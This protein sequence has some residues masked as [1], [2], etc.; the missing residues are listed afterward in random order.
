MCDDM[1]DE[2]DKEIE[3]LD[4]ELQEILKKKAF[5]E[6]MRIVKIEA[7]GEVWYSCTNC[8]YFRDFKGKKL[9]LKK[10]DKDFKEKGIIGYCFHPTKTKRG[11]PLRYITWKLPRN[12][13]SDPC[14]TP[15]K[16]I[17]DDE[18]KSLWNVMF[19]KEN[20]K[21]SKLLDEYSVRKEEREKLRIKRMLREEKLKSKE[22]GRSTFFALKF[23]QKKSNKIQDKE[24]II[25]RRLLGWRI[26]IIHN[27]ETLM[28]KLKNPVDVPTRLELE[29]KLD[30]CKKSIENIRYIETI[31]E[32]ISEI[33]DILDDENLTEE[34]IKLYIQ[35]M[36]DFKKE[37][38]EDPFYST[39]V[40]LEERIGK[41]KK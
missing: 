29:K 3:K 20:D 32:K 6:Y 31:L 10:R 41:R 11:H 38:E 22:E 5:E 12:S 8:E 1:F 17:G 39:I 9:N 13:L 18:E 14:Y 40:Y 7:E 24:T 23:F 34:E 37:L 35:K 16:D 21:L 26:V 28:K 36:K 2:I 25:K 30:E 27:M 4:P 33:S 15:R 19:G